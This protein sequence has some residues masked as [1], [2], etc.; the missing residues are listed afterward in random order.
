MT[1]TY[2]TRIK[3]VCLSSLLTLLFLPVLASA[4][5][6]SVSLSVSPTIIEMS[7]TPGQVW[8]SNLRIINSNPFE[9]TVYAEVV[10]FRPLGEEGNSQFIPPDLGDEVKTTLAEW[11]VV[12]ETALVIG[13]EQTLQIPLRIELPEEATPGGHYAAVLVGTRPTDGRGDE[14]KVEISQVVSSLLFLRAAGDIIEDGD[15]RSFR[16]LKSLV[17]TP[18]VDFELRFENRGNVHIR[19]EGEITI[20]NM[21]GQ[22]RGVIPINR[23]TLFGNI[24]ADSIRSFT[25]TWEGEWSPV[26][27]GRYR[28]EATLVYGEEGRQT[29][30][31]ET[32]FWLLPWRGLLGIILV[33]SI[34]IVLITWFVRLYIRRMLTLAGVERERAKYPEIASTKK[35]LSVTAPIEAGIL[36][37]RSRFANRDSSRLDSILSF[38]SEYRIFF[39]G[40][41]VFVIIAY[42]ISFFI[43]SVSDE[44]R[45][46]EVTVN[47]A[48][49][50]VVLDSESIEY[51]ERQG[52]ETAQ[53]RDVPPLILVNRSGSNG[54]AADVALALE[55]LGY[56]IDSVS[57]DLNQTE[58]KTV[59]VYDPVLADE[60]L[61]LSA[62]L[63]N[64]LL[65]SFE[66][67]SNNEPTITIYIGS[68]IVE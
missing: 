23:K 19:P 11:I 64:A 32:S 15:I 8:E 31:S 41:F 5:T 38:I 46:F 12:P 20:Y 6:E 47:R 25:F 57:A 30:W 35:P 68:D 54:G 7:A 13:A 34:I 28:A 14:S 37:L 52:V 3:L 55:E 4:Q 56:T 62:L 36:D 48:G 59:L 16:A 45:A 21:W 60:A 22:E 43:G 26:D 49:E 33:L 42:I 50:E 53:K 58:E 61:E 2:L 29:A 10:D 17:E 65:S 67:D 9:L 1:L 51:E 44:N 40:F 66:E 27:I 63:N 24:L 39:T 18:K